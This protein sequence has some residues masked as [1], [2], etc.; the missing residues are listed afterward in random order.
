MA[1]EKEG[2]PPA[3][4]DYAGDDE[5]KTE[6]WNSNHLEAY[7]GRTLVKKRKLSA[8]PFSI[9]VKSLAKRMIHEFDLE[10]LKTMINWWAESAPM[11]SAPMFEHFYT[12]RHEVY[13]KIREKDYGDWE[14]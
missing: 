5:E 10:D 13:D 14:T 2:S 7:W 4:I 12:K 11:N 3:L 8:H 9:K 6:A 1:N